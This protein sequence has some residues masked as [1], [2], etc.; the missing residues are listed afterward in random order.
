MSHHT[1]INDY[2]VVIIN[3]IIRQV[4]G[5]TPLQPTATDKDVEKALKIA[6]LAQWP[7]SHP[8]VT[9]P[10]G[11][12]AFGYFGPFSEL[13]QGQVPPSVEA[14]VKQDFKNWEVPTDGGVVEQICRTITTNLFS[15][16][17]QAGQFTGTTPSGPNVDIDWLCLAGLGSTTD[18]VYVFAAATH[19]D[20]G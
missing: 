9:L 13:Q 20:I 18:I 14:V 1:T 8:G 16:G 19:V 3:H 10:G 2:N 5:Q 7:T 15:T 11:H 12:I 17:G 4:P 6:F